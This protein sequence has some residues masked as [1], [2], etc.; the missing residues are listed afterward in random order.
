MTDPLNSAD[1][2][3][4]ASAFAQDGG[5]NSS[6]SADWANQKSA[7]RW[8][9]IVL[10]GL[11]MVILALGIALI[12]IA[13]NLTHKATPAKTELAATAAPAAPLDK[14]AQIALLQAQ[15]A[16]LQAHAPAAGE[17]AS[18]TTS[19]T[20]A[21]P[22]AL[23]QISARMDRLEANQ[24]ALV[25]AASTAYAAR[26][27]QVA[28]SG[29]QPFISELAV[30]EPTIDDPA[31][32]ASLKPFAEKGVPTVVSLAIEFPRVAAKANIAATTTNSDK[33]LLSHIKNALGRMVDVSIRR[34]DNYLGEGAQANILH[35]EMLVNQGD[36]KGALANLSA[37]RP[38]V[39]KAIKP[40][41]DQAKARVLIDDTT[42]RISE[43]AL[44]RL[45][46]MNN[47][48]TGNGDAL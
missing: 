28:A 7:L 42:R 45:S 16:G 19:P 35:A 30:V 47:A 18:V 4:D 38:E 2:A 25:R 33:S 40:W 39:Q 9:M 29:S 5:L 3:N 23:S 22:G 31:L 15:I 13:N 20:Y 8:P 6:D 1:A 46:Q 43:S 36:L 11:P 41:L 10:F 24:R 37:L 44:N 34:T 26:A 32:V 14:D 17:T 27:L 21:D 12:F 48:P